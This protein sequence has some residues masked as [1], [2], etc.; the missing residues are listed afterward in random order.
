MTKAVAELSHPNTVA[1]AGAVAPLAEGTGR[2]PVPAAAAAVT[3]I[4]E[5]PKALPQGTRPALEAAEERAAG[6]KPAPRSLVWT[7][8]PRWPGW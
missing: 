4:M 7:S 2:R 1:A 3:P 8:P 5:V 6:S